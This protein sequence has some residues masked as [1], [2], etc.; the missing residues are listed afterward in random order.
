MATVTAAMLY[1]RATVLADSAPRSFPAWD[2]PLVAAGFWTG[3]LTA[4]KVVARYIGLLVWPA[5]LSCDYSYAQIPLARGAAADWLAWTAVAAVTAMAVLMYRWN[6]TL[7][8]FAGMA[9]LALL[10]ASNL[11]FLTGTIM[12]ERLLY[13][14]AIAA[15]ACVVLAIFAGAER[16]GRSRWAPALLG[17]LV[18]ACAARTWIRNADWSDDLT[19]ATATVRTSPRSYKSHKMLAAALYESDAGPKNVARAIEESEKS[20]AILNALPD[21]QNNPES[22]RRTAVYYMD[23]GAGYER[24]RE[25]FLRSMRIVRASAAPNDPRVPDLYRSLAAVSLRLHDAPGALAAAGEAVRLEPLAPESYGQ[26]ADSL[27]ASDRADDAAIALMEGI[28]LTADG[29]LR[30]ALVD[31][32]R[33]GLDRQSCALIPGTAALNRSCEIVHRHLCQAS[34]AAIRTRLASGDRARADELKRSALID[35]A[36]PETLLPSETPKLP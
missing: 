17:L 21:S 3:R 36:C 18:A 9:A 25:L 19:L 14:P 12:A 30:R 6:R 4:L 7:F 13:L 28:L 22:Y 34:V 5:N 29:N 20:L 10:P 1:Q 2:N 33:Q 27:I 16:L 24:A 31:L 32:Y 8:F 15:A 26:L 23:S 35:F 11:L